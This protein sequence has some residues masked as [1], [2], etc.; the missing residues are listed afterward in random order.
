MSR[1][2]EERAEAAFAAHLEEC[3][4][5][6]T[7]GTTV[8]APEY[9]SIVPG[10][11]KEV[12]PAESWEEH[13]KGSTV[14]VAEFCTKRHFWHTQTYAWRF[15]ATEAEARR[16]LHATL[17]HRVEDLENQITRL[18]KQITALETAGLAPPQGF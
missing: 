14:Y 17:R 5:V 3:A 7:V 15:F 13:P 1:A 11:V 4:R 18:R 8:W 16:E 10:V 9:D 2:A 6:F 12:R